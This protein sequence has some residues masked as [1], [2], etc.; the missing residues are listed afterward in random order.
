MKL[1]SKL[2]ACIIP[3][4][5]IGVL[6]G[7]TS[8]YCRGLALKMADLPDHISVETKQGR[9]FYSQGKDE[10]EIT[11]ERY[12]AFTKYNTLSTLLMVP[13]VVLVS[14]AMFFVILI[15]PELKKN[16]DYISHGK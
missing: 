3:M 7:M 9:F 4:F 5:I 1:P 12:W 8:L 6:L 15:S 13:G 16:E 10:Y 11:E 14:G 2:V